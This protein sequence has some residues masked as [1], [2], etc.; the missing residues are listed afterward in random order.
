MDT[1]KL[2][3]IIYKV[4]LNKKK[5]KTSERSSITKE[6]K[7]NLRETGMRN[8]EIRYSQKTITREEGPFSPAA[9][10]LSPTLDSPAWGPA[11]G[12]PTQRKFGFEA[13]SSLF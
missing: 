9:R 4:T 1:P 5:S 2:Q 13:K 8:V 10:G 7:G 6:I 12:R 11:L 3:A